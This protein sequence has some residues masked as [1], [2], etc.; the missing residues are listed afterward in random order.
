MECRVAAATLC[1]DHRLDAVEG[2]LLANGV[3]VIAAIGEQC[4]S[5]VRNHPEQRT[6]TLHVVGLAGRQDKSERATFPVAAR[7]E[8][9]GEAAARSAKRL[10][11]LSPFFMPTAQ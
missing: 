2:D 6:E 5:F 1:R 3:S 8:F 11:L 9:G 7:V 10:G 4:L